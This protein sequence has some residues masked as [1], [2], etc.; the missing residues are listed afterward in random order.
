VIVP[1]PARRPEVVLFDV[2]ETL[3]QLD[4]LRPRFVEVGR[5]PHELDLFFARTLRDGMA[6]TLAGDA[7]PF[8]DVARAELA[9]TSKLDD[10]QIDHVLAGFSELPLQ[11]DALPAFEALDR[12]GIP[13]YAFTHG[14]PDVVESAM[15]RAGVRGRFAGVFSAEAI[16][17]FKPP[18]RVYHW[19]CARIGSTPA[20]T[21]LVAAH[22][23]DTHGAVR[24]GLLAGLATRL[25][26]GPP[27]VVERPHVVAERVDEVVAGLLGLPQ[28]E[29]VGGEP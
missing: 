1:V 2:F 16:H 12:A 29:T 11:A 19:V 25:E 15:T 9:A 22:S 14:S 3:L 21:A 7:P 26:G 8:R 18:A 28:G 24:A 17:S 10:E 6:Y 5:P 23:W 13:F 20:A 4:A 27:A